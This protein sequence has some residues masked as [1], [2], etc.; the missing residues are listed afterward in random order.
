MQKETLD[1]Y[2]T[3]SGAAE[4]SRIDIT[5]FFN[6]IRKILGEREISLKQRIS[7]ILWKQESNLRFKVFLFY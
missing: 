1:A 4:K 5:Q 6:D 3:L 7:E 2:Q